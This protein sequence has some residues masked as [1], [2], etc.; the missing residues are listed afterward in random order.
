MNIEDR[1]WNASLEEMKQGYAWDGETDG[2]V[3]LVCGAVFEDG[4]M[5]EHEGAYYEAKRATRY[6][7]EDMH[8]SMLSC[9]LGLDKKATG[10]TELQKQLIEGF[11]SGLSDADMMAK[12]GAGSASTI[13]N[14]RFALKVKSKQAKLLL[15]VIEMMEQGAKRQLYGVV[16]R[17]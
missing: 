15:V 2:Y 11:A 9:L 8:G 7:V 10:L 13:R 3:C 14:H 5:Y 12:T 1:F 17:H 6:H 4:R 16:V